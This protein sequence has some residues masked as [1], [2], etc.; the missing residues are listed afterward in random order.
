MSYSSSYCS[1]YSSRHGNS[2]ISRNVTASVAG[3]AAAAIGYHSSFGVTAM[4]E[5]SPEEV[6]KE[7]A[8]SQQ[9]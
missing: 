1:S 3:F 6:A 7:A 2:Y 9:F 5:G 8:V 4:E